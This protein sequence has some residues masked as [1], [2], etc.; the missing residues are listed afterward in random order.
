MAHRTQTTLTDDQYARLRRES[1]RS[2]L[3]LAELVRR[4]LDRRYGAVDDEGA[5]A[6]LSD[7]F[8]AWPARDLDGEAYVEGLRRGVARRLSR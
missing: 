5:E 2:G 1:E 3:G 8:G 4:A 6:A 7:S